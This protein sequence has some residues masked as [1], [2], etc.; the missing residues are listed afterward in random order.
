M[1]F[2]VLLCDYRR[3]VLRYFRHNASVSEVQRHKERFG[4]R[5]NNADIL[6]RP[7]FHH[8]WVSAPEQSP[9]L[10]RQKI[11]KK[12]ILNIKNDTKYFK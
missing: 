1:Q 6:H 4:Q 11:Y 3:P 12:I 2:L 10:N 9:I 7:I 8:A 5:N